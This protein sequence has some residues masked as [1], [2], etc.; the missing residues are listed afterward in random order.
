M[1]LHQPHLTS[2][3]HLDELGNDSKK[4]QKTG[5]DCF[6]AYGDLFSLLDPSKKAVF[7]DRE[8]TFRHILNAAEAME[9]DPRPH[10]RPISLMR[11]IDFFRTATEHFGDA[12][13]RIREGIDRYRMLLSYYQNP[14]PQTLSRIS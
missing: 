8:F 2:L 14:G 4:L 1:R 11:G 7:K 5:T 9:F 13:H 10:V 3:Q 12:E 6:C